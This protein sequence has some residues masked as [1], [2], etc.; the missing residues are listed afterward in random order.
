MQ[1]C[2]QCGREFEGNFGDSP[3]SLN[4]PECDERLAQMARAGIPTPPQGTIVTPSFPITTALIGLN[5][6]VFLIMVLRGVSFLSPSPQQAIAFGAD[7][8]PLTLNGQWWRLLTSM[9]VHFGILHIGLNMWCLWNL[10]RAAEQLMGRVSYLLA[11][12]VSGIFSSIASVYWHP[13]GASA[14]ASGAIFGMAGVL[15][16]YVKLK[17]TPSHLTINSKMLGSLGTF[18]AYNLAFGALPGISNAAHIGG[19]LMGLAVGAVLP[20]ASASESSRRTRLTLVAI[21]SAI[22]LLGSAVAAKKLNS[23]VS[24]LTSAEQLLA[25]KKTDEA[26][27]RLQQ[28]TAREP[29]FGPGHELLARAYLVKSQYPEAIAELQKAYDTNPKSARYQQELGTLYVQLGMMSAATTFFKSLEEQNPKNAFAHFGLGQISLS[30]GEYDSAIPEFQRALALDPQLRGA[31]FSLGQAQLGARHY[32]DAQATFESILKQDPND[33][34]AQAG[35][36]YV[37]SQPH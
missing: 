37:T 19:L 20:A 22:A 9:F 33:K 14:G 11:Y 2:P 7:F 29:G 8:G 31:A 6:L 26:L 1:R 32:P 15:V 25:Q 21:F 34:R 13:M 4:C 35:L 3:H 24:E 16:A 27:T 17:K 36:A 30:K 10:G 18:I 5:A 28:L 12:F 23:Q